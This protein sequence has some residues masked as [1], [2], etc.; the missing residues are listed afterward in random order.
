M[1]LSAVVL[2]GGASRRFGGDKLVQP[3]GGRPLIAH[4]LDSAA[5]APVEELLLLA[6][7]T[8]VA[9]AGRRWGRGRGDV[10]LRVVEIETAEEGLGASLRAA[11][12]LV[13]SECDGLF[14]FL[15]DMPFV[16][17]GIAMQLAVLIQRGALAAAPA[18]EGRRGHPVLL[19]APLIGAL[20]TL[21]GERGAA[22]LLEDAALIQVGHDGIVFDVDTP[23]ALREAER[24][25]AQQQRPLPPL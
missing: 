5:A 18:F 24:R 4:A 9:E 23:A 20:H 10:A 14:I 8:A 15:G 21:Q 22:G 11:A 1:R 17:A 2:A 19:A 25:L 6:G 13:Q 3:L 12:Q 7:S 16:P